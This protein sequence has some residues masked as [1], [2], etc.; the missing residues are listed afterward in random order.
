[1]LAGVGI[2]EGS[3]IYMSFLYF[4]KKNVA[5]IIMMI[6]RVV[7]RIGQKYVVLVSWI[8]VTGIW[9]S[10]SLICVV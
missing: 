10:D 2:E 3:S 5:V 7:I 4:R 9:F 1:M 8:S 6:I